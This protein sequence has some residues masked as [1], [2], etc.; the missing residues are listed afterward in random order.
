MEKA[1][2]AR[3]NKGRKILT[4]PSVPCFEFWLLLHFTYTTKQFD[5][6][7]GGSICD[8]VIKEL[9]KYLPEYQKGNKDIFEKIQD[10]LNIAIS[11]AHKVEEF[12]Q[13]SGADNPSSTSVHL[14]VEY[15]QGF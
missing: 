8:T 10:K 3:L 9:K 11:N 2:H 4:I 7:A 5:A 14:L 13:T 1:E 12:N 15:L 6:P